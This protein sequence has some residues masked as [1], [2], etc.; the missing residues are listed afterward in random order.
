MTQRTF[1]LLD[2]DVVREMRQ[3]I[4]SHYGRAAAMGRPLV[5]TVAEHHARRSGSQNRL[6]H[7]LLN[8]IAENVMVEGRKYDASFWKELIR[9][10][11]IG[12]EE[13]QLPDGTRIERGISTTTLSKGEFAALID[14]VTAFAVTE[15]GLEPRT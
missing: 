8:E 13:M 10:R 3:F 15:L 11:F 9:R 12:T 14:Q 1:I 2:A 5:V 7:A 4:A 6:L